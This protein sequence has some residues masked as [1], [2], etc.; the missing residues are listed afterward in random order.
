MRSVSPKVVRPPP[1]RVG[2]VML[3]AGSETGW[4]WRMSIEEQELLNGETPYLPP[5]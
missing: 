3:V 2:K 1:P 4:P 5:E